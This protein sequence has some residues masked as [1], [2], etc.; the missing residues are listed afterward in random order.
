[1][2]AA[3]PSVV[4]AISGSIAAYKAVEVARLLIQR[5]IR[6]RPIMTRAAGKFVGAATLSGICG[7]PV[8]SDMFAPG[9]SGELHV[10]LGGEADVVALV[11]ATADL[12]AALAQGRAD[13][14]VRAT[15][16]CARG[17]LVA[18]PAMHPRM[19]QHPATQRNVAQ[20]TA[21]GRVRFVGPVAGEV[22]SGDV[23][24]GRMAEPSSIADA[25]AACLASRDLADRHIV[26]SAG[27]TVED[28]DPARYLSNRSSGKMG[29][30][31]AERAAL[32]GAT[33]TLIAGPVALA[34][35]FGVTRWDVRSARDMGE[36]LDRTLA[37]AD[38]LVMTAAVADYRPAETLPH[39]LKREGRA[40]L[41]LALV[42]NPDLLADIGAKRRGDRPYLVGFALETA[43]DE[44]LVAIARAKLAH[45]GVDL[46]VA[47]RAAEAFERDDN[48]ATLVTAGDAEALPRMDKRALADRILDRVREALA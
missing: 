27:P 15:A 28:I 47:N 6:V 35:P 48:R 33:V 29:F 42:Q 16:L 9:V 26:V 3:R 11:P 1:M 34:T 38:A 13:D 43:E 14:L 2:T 44:E 18:A 23:G 36:A 5:G 17:P 45:K 24:M 22:A 7:E 20:L 31:I 46:I 25:I 39:K 37:T 32:R 30:A 41:T 8:Y 12:I 4:L 21:D 10:A 19:W 40:E